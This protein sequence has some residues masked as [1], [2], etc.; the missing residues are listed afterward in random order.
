MCISIENTES[1][2]DEPLCI[3]YSVYA[4]CIRGTK[5]P[6]DCLGFYGHTRQMSAVWTR[7]RTYAH[8]GPWG[9]CDLPS[10]SSSSVEEVSVRRGLLL[11]LGQE[12]HDEVA[13]GEVRPAVVVQQRHGPAQGGFRHSS[14]RHTQTHKRTN[15]H[16]HKRRNTQT[17]KHTSWTNAETNTRTNAETNTHTNA[18]TF[19]HIN[20]HTFT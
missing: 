6:K 10:S 9:R 1:Y 15:T 14:G 4:S 13:A 3:L 2:V 20:T 18:E 12:V 17:Q 8:T 16:T 19:T 7:S 11:R 5:S